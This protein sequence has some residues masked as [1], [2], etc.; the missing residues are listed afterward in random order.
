MRDSKGKFIKGNT[1]AKRDFTKEKARSMVSEE[2]FLISKLIADMPKEELDEYLS[3]HKE[4]MTLL[5][6]K[7]IDKIKKGDM[8]AIQWFVE[9]LVG[10]A[11]QHLEHSTP[12]GKKFQLA[13]NL[14]GSN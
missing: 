11:S 8:K 3:V 13:Y 5:S 4:Q 2:L 7:I 6:L 14:D 10:R 1:F 9:I 12:E